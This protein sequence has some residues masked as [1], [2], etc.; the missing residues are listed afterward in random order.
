MRKMAPTNEAGYWKP[1]IEIDLNDEEH[2]TLAEC[3]KQYREQPETFTSLQ[4][5]RGEIG[6]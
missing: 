2:K 6:V 3:R 1:V 5:I 4:D